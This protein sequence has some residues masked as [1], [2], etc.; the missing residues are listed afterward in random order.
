MGTITHTTD[1]SEALGALRESGCVIVDDALA[2]SE[3]SDLATAVTELEQGRPLGR[4]VFE[5]ERSHRLYSLIARGRPFEELAQHPVALALLDAMQ[6]MRATPPAAFDIG[7]AIWR[8][9]HPSDVG[10]WLQII[11]ILAFAIVGGMF[12]AAMRAR[13]APASSREQL[14]RQRSEVGD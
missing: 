13:R 2:P 4:N 11:G 14:L 9:S 8:I 6:A 3:I 5:G 1:V 10:G 7:A 12:I